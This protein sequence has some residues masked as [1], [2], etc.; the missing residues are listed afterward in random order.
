MLSLSVGNIQFPEFIGSSLSSDLHL[1][2]HKTTHALSTRQKQEGVSLSVFQFVCQSVG[3]SVCQ[4][5][6][7]FLVHTISTSLRLIFSI[8]I[9]LFIESSALKMETKVTLFIPLV[10][11]FCVRAPSRSY[12][13]IYA[14]AHPSKME[15]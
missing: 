4:F 14:Q 12:R 7:S 2:L 3:L 11:I 8:K 10:C 1:Y 5:D 13:G 15:S 6:C 9:N